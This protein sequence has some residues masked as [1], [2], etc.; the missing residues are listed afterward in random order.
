LVE[1]PATHDL[2]RKGPW[3]LWEKPRPQVDVTTGLQVT[4]RLQAWHK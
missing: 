2:K 4:R 1:K 3:R